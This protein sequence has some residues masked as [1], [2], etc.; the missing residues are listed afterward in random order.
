MTAGI[1]IRISRVGL[2]VIGFAMSVGSQ[3]A[4]ADVVAVVSSKSAIT[5]LTKNEV[6]DI[7]LGKVSRFPNGVHAVPIDQAEDSAAREEFY[8][9]L[10]GKS[11]AQMKA[12]WAK[13]IFTGRGQPP[14][15][16][17]S[18]AEMKKRIAESPSAI[19][20]LDSSFVDDSVRV[21]Q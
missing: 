4:V 16:M 21:V 5:T 17:R 15:E 18:N 10:A 19:G 11:A 2:F 6:V 7:F 13:I 9:K 12:Y 1:M 14:Q 3:P 8:A 20:Y